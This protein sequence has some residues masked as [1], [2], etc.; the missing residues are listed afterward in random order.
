MLHP[1]PLLTFQ[2]RSLVIYSDDLAVVKRKDATLSALDAEI[3]FELKPFAKQRVA[4]AAG[5]ETMIRQQGGKF[6]VNCAAMRALQPA[7][8]TLRHSS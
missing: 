2:L 5:N 6:K 8:E 4:R 1:F 3:S 7:V